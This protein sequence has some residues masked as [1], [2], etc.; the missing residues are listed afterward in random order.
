MLYQLSYWLS[1]NPPISR[2]EKKIKCKVPGK[3]T[4]VVVENKILLAWRSRFFFGW[5]FYQRTCCGIAY[6]MVW[7]VLFIPVG[8][9]LSMNIVAQLNLLTWGGVALTCLIFFLIELK[10]VSNDGDRSKRPLWIMCLMLVTL[11]SSV[12]F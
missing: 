11:A 6:T 1:S 2:I 5:G 4:R 8:I 7:I 10:Q 12:L 3:R 9:W